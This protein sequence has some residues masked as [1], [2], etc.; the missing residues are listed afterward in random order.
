MAKSRRHAGPLKSLFADQRRA[1]EDA[2]PSG[3]ALEDVP[4][5]PPMGDVRR[6]A[7]HAAASAPAASK[8]LAATILPLALVLAGEFLLW[9]YFNNRQRPQEAAEKPALDEAEAVVAMKPVAPESAATLA[10]P[11]AKQQL[12]EMFES[13]RSNLSN[14]KDAASAEAALPQLE[15]LNGRLDT[16]RTAT[17]SLPETA[18]TALREFVSE[19]FSAINVQ[20]E[21]VLTLPGL[22]EQLKTILSEII[23]K[24]GDM[25]TSLVGP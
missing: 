9:S 6:S 21:R 12:T 25:Q 5:L 13:L 7:A 23:H 4:G 3:F 22:P 14:I 24:L 19:Q 20:A 1:I 15:Q 10:A 8:S 2:L 17:R 11:A 18:R 16:L